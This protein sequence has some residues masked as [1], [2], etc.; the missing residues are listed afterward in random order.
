MPWLRQ[1][2]FFVAF[3]FTLS[4]ALWAPVVVGDVRSNVAGFLYY[5]GVIGP[6]AAAVGLSFREGDAARARLLRAIGRWRV[7]MRWY[8]AALLLPFVIRAIA[9]VGYVA[10]HGEGFRLVFRPIENLLPL[11]ALVLLLVPFE[12]IGWRGYLLPRIA[13]RFGLL[14]SSLI[15]GVIWALWHLPLFWYREG[16]QGS[17]DPITYGIRFTATILPISCIATWLYFES[18]ES[19][20]VVSIYHFAVNMADVALALPQS[21][22]NMLQWIVM[23]VGSLVVLA[24]A[25]VLR[26]LK[27]EN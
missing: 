26:E 5:A 27:I 1:T 4:W 7:P 25:A 24:L 19:I 8:L 15:V 2:F 9:V 18:R 3:A 14:T 17:D 20:A 22:G 13:N 16:F 23:F 11:A 10:F 21:I 12:E 6:C